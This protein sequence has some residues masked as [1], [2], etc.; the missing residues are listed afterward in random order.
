MKTL[1][2]LWKCCGKINIFFTSRKLLPH[3]VRNKENNYECTSNRERLLTC[4]VGC[5]GSTILCHTI[6]NDG[7]QLSVCILY[8]ITASLPHYYIRVGNSA[9]GDWQKLI[10]LKRS[11]HHQSI[12]WYFEI[13][14]LLLKKR[15]TL[16]NAS[17]SKEA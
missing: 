9:K 2:L 1:H 13:L 8:F 16:I 12:F 6:S 3:K 11:L 14:S 4:Y 7:N 5:P 10:L 17:A 15:I